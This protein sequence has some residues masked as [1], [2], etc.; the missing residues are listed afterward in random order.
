MEKIKERGISQ[1]VIDVLEYSGHDL[2]DWL[3]GFNSVE[4]SIKENVK[5]IKDHPLIPKDIAVHGL[6]MSPETGE[7]NVVVNGYE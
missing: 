1:E 3:R 2:K 4:E 6:V 7:I 5:T